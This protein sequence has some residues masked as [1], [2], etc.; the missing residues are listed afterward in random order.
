M[1]CSCE[2]FC[3]NVGCYILWCALFRNGKQTGETVNSYKKEAGNAVSQPSKTAPAA[4]SR[5]KDVQKIL[6]ESNNPAELGDDEQATS[7]PE[8][9]SRR[10]RRHTV[11]QVSLFPQPCLLHKIRWFLLSMVI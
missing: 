6:E 7:I 9:S 8:K 4:R 1:C 11:L 5:R 10:Q 2:A 3:C